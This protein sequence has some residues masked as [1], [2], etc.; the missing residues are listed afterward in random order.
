M[1]IPQQAQDL[2][3]ARGIE[4]DS[5][6]TKQGKIMQHFCKPGGGIAQEN[7]RIYPRI[8]YN[9]CA[10]KQFFKSYIRTDFFK[11]KKIPLFRMGSYIDE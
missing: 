9:K 4:T 6:V 7:K 5:P 8:I 1:E 11:I 3:K 2:A 10:G